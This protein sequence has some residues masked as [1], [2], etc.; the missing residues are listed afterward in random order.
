MSLIWIPICEVDESKREWPARDE[1]KLASLIAWFQER[2]REIPEEYREL[3]ECAIETVGDDYDGGRSCAELI[4][5]YWREETEAEAAEREAAELAA[6]A[7]RKAFEIE[8]L[9]ARLRELDK[10][11]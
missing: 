8:M 1:T 7:R 9:Q 5:G 10:Q 11:A 6:L 3:A 4:I 2:L